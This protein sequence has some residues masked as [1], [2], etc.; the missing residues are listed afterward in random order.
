MQ[1]GRDLATLSAKWDVSFKS[2]PSE[3]RE[4]ESVRAGD[5]GHQGKKAFQ[6]NMSRAHMDSQGLKQQAQDLR[7]SV[8]GPLG[9]F[10]RIPEHANEWISTSVISLTPLLLSIG[11][12]VIAFVSSYYILLLYVLHE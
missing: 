11:F 2:L 12:D 3:L 1:R 8:P 5:R 7:G 6:I 10:Y 9:S 4:T